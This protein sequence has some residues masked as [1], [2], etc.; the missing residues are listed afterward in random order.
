MT[1]EDKRAII[2]TEGKD[3]IPAD[4]AAGYLLVWAIHDGFDARPSLPY[5]FI[6]SFVSYRSI[7]I[8]K[9]YFIYTY[10]EIIRSKFSKR[11]I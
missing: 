8:F 5:F 3:E 7:K 1:F 9:R 2:N 6:S 4:L 10:H 11:V